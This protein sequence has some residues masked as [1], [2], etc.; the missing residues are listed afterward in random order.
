MKIDG[1]S[2]RPVVVDGYL[3]LEPSPVNSSIELDF[4]ATLVIDLQHP[5]LDASRG[6]MAVRHR[7][8]NLCCTQS[9]M[10]P[11]R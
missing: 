3:V 10:E 1:V 5:R 9:S 11:H 4:H 8:L 2:A 7:P 6:T